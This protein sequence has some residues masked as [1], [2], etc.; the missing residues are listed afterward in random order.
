[1]SDKP[2]VYAKMNESCRIFQFKLPMEV[3]PV[4]FNGLSTDIQ[5]VSNFFVY[6]T[7]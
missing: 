5:I 4:G 3:S 2:G 7:L 6:K 1:M